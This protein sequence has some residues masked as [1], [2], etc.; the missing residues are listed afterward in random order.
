MSK[1]Y[2]QNSSSSASGGIGIL[3]VLQIVFVVLKCLEL[4]DWSWWAVLIPTF[5]SIG[6][7]VIIVAAI[8][9]AYKDVLFGGKKK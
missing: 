6:I 5:I 4:I 1:Y 3:G 2:K 8:L 7:M 9:I